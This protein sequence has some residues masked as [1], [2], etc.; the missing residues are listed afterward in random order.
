MNVCMCVYV[1]VSM[2]ICVLVFVSLACRSRSTFTWHSR[3]THRTFSV[4]KET[5][6]AKLPPSFLGFHFFSLIFNNDSQI[7]V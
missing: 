2:C 1:C 7:D 5:C 3:R 4:S 6:S